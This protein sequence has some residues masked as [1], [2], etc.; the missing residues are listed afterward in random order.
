[1][2]SSPSGGAVIDTKDL[3][4]TGTADVGYGEHLNGE[5]AGMAAVTDTGTWG[6]TPALPVGTYTLA[7][8]GT[9]AAGLPLARPR[10]D[11]LYNRHPGPRRWGAPVPPPLR[12]VGRRDSGA[13]VAPPPR[14]QAS[15]SVSA[16]IREAGPGP[17]VPCLSHP[18]RGLR[19]SA[20]AHTPYPARRSSSLPGG[21]PELRQPPLRERAQCSCGRP[22]PTSNNSPQELLWLDLMEGVLQYELEN[23]MAA[24]WHS[25]AP[26]GAI[27]RPSSPCQALHPSSRILRERPQAHPGTLQCR[28]LC[29]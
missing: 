21:R 4:V 3:T 22:G 17:A 15:C 18:W 1:M 28:C 13:R 29:G 5:E 10:I 19:E 11:L 7:A 9:D 14:A 16:D 27:A 24:R 6:F 20:A 8:K 26:W 25:P 2:R 23:E 12:W